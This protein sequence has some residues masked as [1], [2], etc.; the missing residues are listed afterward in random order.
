MV[1]RGGYFNGVLY[2]VLLLHPLI[3][4]GKRGGG[5]RDAVDLLGGQGRS[6]ERYLVV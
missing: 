2:R 5:I 3:D 6:I 1:E 4:G